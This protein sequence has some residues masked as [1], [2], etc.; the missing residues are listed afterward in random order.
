M[1]KAGKR[2]ILIT[3]SALLV[4]FCIGVSY[5][6][7]TGGVEDSYHG[8]LGRING[9][10]NG[11]GMLEKWCAL[12]YFNLEE[13]GQTAWE[14]KCGS[15]HIGASWSASK[16]IANCSLCHQTTGSDKPTGLTEA[17]TVD[18]CMTCHKKD[19]A[20]RGDV[21]DAENDVHIAAGMNCQDCHPR[22]S[23]EYSDHQIA[24]GTVIDTTEDTMEGS[25]YTCADCHGLRPHHHNVKHGGKPD[26]DCD[27]VAC[28]ERIRHKLQREYL[29]L[30]KHCDEVAC[31]VCHTGLRPGSALA[32]RTWA[33]FNADGK[34]VTEMRGTDWLPEHKWYSSENVKGHLPILGYTE[35]KDY[36]GAKIYAF[37]PVTV[38]WFITGEENSDLDDSIVVADVKAADADEDSETTEAEMRAYNNAQYP[39]ATLV[40]EDMNFQISHSVTKEDAFNCDDC[41]GDTGWVLDWTQLG[42]DADP[43]HKGNIG[44]KR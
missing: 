14:T 21:F 5:A 19:T 43:R 10:G 33:K 38:T 41:H 16:S 31:E 18:K 20:K 11:L 15:C 3:L 39:T 4:V 24:K 35:H 42:Y 37:N 25:M 2:T 30:D 44:K 7:T 40:T 13:Q 36:Q 17:P 22:L 32:S 9:G 28:E 34:P 23:D 27:E 8:Q 1:K 6:A 12:P 26:K 29:M